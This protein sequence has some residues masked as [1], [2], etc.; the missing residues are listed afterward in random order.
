MMTLINTFSTRMKRIRRLPIIATLA[1]AIAVFA[2][3]AFETTTSGKLAGNTLDQN[4]LG[5]LSAAAGSNSASRLAASPIAIGQEAPNRYNANPD[6]TADFL[7]TED[8]REVLSFIV[9]CTLPEGTTLVATLPD[10]STLEFFGDLGLANEWLGHPLKKAGRGWV[11]ACLFA[12]VNSSAIA[13]PI[14]LRGPHQA[15]TVS[16]EEASTWPLEEGAFYGDYF[17]APGEPVQWVACRGR[18][19]AAGEIGGLISRDCT[20]PDPNNPGR[21]K[22]GFTYAGDCGSFAAAYVCDHFSPAGCYRN[23]QDQPGD[24]SN[25]DK[26]RQVITVFALAP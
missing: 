23:C 22:C 3:L 17:V 14:S 13:V 24:E 11:S 10:N 21:T 1:C 25:S 5:P 4:K 2:M 18:D 16:P 20:E 15:L 19:Q 9:S 12:R 6:T 7:A 26:F 8:G